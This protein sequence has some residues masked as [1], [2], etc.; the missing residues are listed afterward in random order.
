MI[1]YILIDQVQEGKAALVS[2]NII[3]LFVSKLSLRQAPL[4][5]NNNHVKGQ[6]K[7]YPMGWR[8]H[9]VMK[10]IVGGSE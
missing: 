8:Y 6:F 1:L 5:K 3:H 7:R 10:R 2:R 4:L 9:L